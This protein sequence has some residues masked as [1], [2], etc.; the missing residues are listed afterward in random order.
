MFLPPLLAYTGLMVRPHPLFW[1]V[2]HGVGVLYTMLLAALFVM[3]LDEGR[4]FFRI[5]DPS[6]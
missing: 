6:V 3:D 2:T 1:R 4:A 5:I